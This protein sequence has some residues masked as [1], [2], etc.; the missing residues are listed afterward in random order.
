MKLWLITLLPSNPPPFNKGGMVVRAETEEEARLRAV[1][2]LTY[3][4]HEVWLDP[5]RTSIRV[6]R[7]A[8]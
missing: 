5:D 1:R 4:G 7:T 8:A 2:G 3:E 6:L